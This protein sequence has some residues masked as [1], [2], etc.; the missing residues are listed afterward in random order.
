M[1]RTSFPRLAAATLL[2]AVTVGL[3]LSGCGPAQ[4]QP[5]GS[6]TDPAP[7]GAPDIGMRQTVG[8]DNGVHTVL[9][10][11]VAPAEQRDMSI[12]VPVTGTLRPRRRAVVT[13]KQPG[14]VVAIG[15]RQ[16]GE[17]G[18]LL[19]GTPVARGDVLVTL[20]NQALDLQVQQ[21]K[22]EIAS[23]EYGTPAYEQ[24]LREEGRLGRTE[25]VT[26]EAES[27]LQTARENLRRLTEAHEQGAI[28]DAQLE[29]A[30]LQYDQARAGLDKINISL[31]ELRRSLE[32]MEDMRAD[33]Q[34]RA[35]FDGRIVELN[36]E[37]G[38][39][40]S[41][42]APV[43]VLMDDSSLD[44]EFDVPEQY[45]PYLRVDPRER[46]VVVTVPGYDPF[47]RPLLSV[48]PE[49]DE[50]TR[51]IACRCRIPNPE[52]RI[53]AGLFATG[54]IRLT[55]PGLY[56]P[57]AA[58]LEREGEFFV[59]V[60]DAEGRVTQRWIQR[61]I[62]TGGQ[63]GVGGQASGWVQ[64]LRGTEETVVRAGDRLLLGAHAEIEEGDT[65]RVSAQTPAVAD[66][67]NNR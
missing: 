17:L 18:E 13:A 51:T 63:V 46:A 9:P 67:A 37:I 50:T 14:T 28:P 55:I 6:A 38:E 53:Q 36:V 42:P 64:I 24:R 39:F 20:T 49:V 61:G 58:T 5:P 45:G 47:W 19:T 23:L 59:R 1:Q 30:Q 48:N 34:V 21:L 56:V 10:S 12:A 44:F 4:A 2:L 7:N 11:H 29:A 62:T 15:E 26:S 65:V 54:E 57:E 22:T 27:A 16:P 3:T 8:G 33:L 66:G 25:T 60:L 43:A 31:A 40:T 41:P 32:I 35:P 52:G